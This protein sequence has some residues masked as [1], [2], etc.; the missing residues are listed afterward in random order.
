[1]EEIFEEIVYVK[2]EPEE[3]VDYPLS[4]IEVIA[5]PLEIDIPTNSQLVNQYCRLCLREMS[6]LFPLMSRVQN[7]MIPDMIAAVTGICVNLRDK[8]PKKVCIQCLVKVDYAYHIRKEFAESNQVLKNFAASRVVKLWDLLKNY[9]NGVLAKSET[10]SEKLLRENRDIIRMRL[11]KKEEQLANMS[12]VELVDMIDIA[13]SKPL[14]NT[15]RTTESKSIPHNHEVKAEGE[16][17]SQEIEMQSTNVTD[18]QEWYSEDNS[19]EE[20]ISV[21]EERPEKNTKE[22]KTMKILHHTLVVEDTEPDP[23]KCYICLEQF[24]NVNSL[25][26]HLPDHIGMVPFQCQ[27]CKDTVMETKAIATVIMMHRHFRMHAALNKCP[28]CPFRCYKAGNLYSHFKRYHMTD[29]KTERTCEICGAK[30]KNPKTFENHK[31]MHKAIEESRFTCSFCSKKFA[32]RARLQRHERIHTNE[33]PYSCRYCVKSFT[34]ETSFQAH[35]RQHTGERGYRCEVCGK[36]YSTHNEL[37]AH[38][39]SAHKLA[40]VKRSGENAI[41]RGKY[42][43]ILLKCASE[44]CNF[45]TTTY[46]KYYQH[47]AKHVLSFHCQ[48]CE[49]RFPTK[50]RLEMHEF[51]HTNTKRYCCDICGK[52]FRYRVSF[53]E[54]MDSHNNKRTHTCKICSLSFV[55]QRNLKEHMKKHSDELEYA[56][57]HCGKKFRYRA[58][59]SKH[60]RTHTN[61]SSKSQPEAIVESDGSN[62]MNDMVDAENYAIE[63]LEG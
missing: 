52:N 14:V 1:M 58:D 17:L 27:E 31:R 55:R 33:R 28:E 40:T 16:L 22:S 18:N 3:P 11:I 37:S 38:L 10:R 56:C 36:G 5:C 39:A 29:S 44:G 9:Q 48:Y 59:L 26:M 57:R 43:K 35:E 30:I 4:Q 15:E 62:E 21:K 53:V 45:E 32:T 7:V 51:V 54:H 2:P 47:R 25:E 12:G 41:H 60:V 49:E 13:E 50:Q 23:N 6:T 8:L 24:S 61:D 63:Y 46:S 19:I 42:S 20:I 34:N